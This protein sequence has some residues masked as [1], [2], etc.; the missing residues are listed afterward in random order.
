MTSVTHR[1]EQVVRDKHGASYP[2]LLFWT[3]RLQTES[4]CKR[5]T[6]NISAAAE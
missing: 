6:R 4:T 2:F 1:L 3:L 5:I